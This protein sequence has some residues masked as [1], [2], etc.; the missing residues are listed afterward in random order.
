MAFPL[1]LQPCRCVGEGSG[2]TGVTVRSQWHDLLSCYAC[3]IACDRAANAGRDSIQR[4]SASS[5]TPPLRRTCSLEQTAQ[6]M[7]RCSMLSWLARVVTSSSLVAGRGR[8]CNYASVSKQHSGSPA[9]LLALSGVYAGDSYRQ[10]CR[11]VASSCSARK[12]N[13]A[14]HH[15]ARCTPHLHYTLLAERGS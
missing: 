11:D 15:N 13:V 10:Q 4:R 1:Q 7:T 8:D 3:E 6:L 12:T 5:S 2:G 14:T 9:R